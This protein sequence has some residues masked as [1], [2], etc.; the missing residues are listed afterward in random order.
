MPI[1]NTGLIDK[2]LNLVKSGHSLVLASPALKGR[3]AIIVQLNPTQ[4][5]IGISIEMC[6]CEF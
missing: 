5:N 1:L 3:S 2:N 4:Y 6:T